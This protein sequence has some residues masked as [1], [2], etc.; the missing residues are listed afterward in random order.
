M[1]KK[2]GLTTFGN[3]LWHQPTWK[4]VSTIPVVIYRYTH[5]PKLC[6]PTCFQY[7]WQARAFF[8]PGLQYQLQRKIPCKG[9]WI[10]EDNRWLMATVIFC[11]ASC[12]TSRIENTVTNMNICAP[13]SS[14][15]SLPTYPAKK[16]SNSS[17]SSWK[18]CSGIV[19]TFIFS[20]WRRVVITTPDTVLIEAL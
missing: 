3:W 18:N 7:W 8:D 9:L 12:V 17:E 19:R 4:P 16:I 5:H 11:A 20:N 1:Q 10:L 14:Q 13:W 2:A 6:L 15:P